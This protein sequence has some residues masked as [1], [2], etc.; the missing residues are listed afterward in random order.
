MITTQWCG[1][2]Y[3]LPTRDSQ[4]SVRLQTVS[5]RQEGNKYMNGDRDKAGC[6]MVMPAVPFHV[7]G[8]QEAIW[9]STCSIF[10]AV[11]LAKSFGERV[12]TPV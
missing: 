3:T 4:A 12:D 8:T 5:L 2:L 6:F 9:F 11:S 10:Q 7:E 1:M